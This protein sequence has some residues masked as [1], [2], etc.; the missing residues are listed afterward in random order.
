MKCFVTIVN[1]MLTILENHF[2]WDVWQGTEDDS[3]HGLEVKIKSNLKAQGS[4]TISIIYEFFFSYQSFVSQTLKIWNAEE[5][6]GSSLFLSTS[7]THSRTLTL[8]YFETLHLKT[9][10]RN[11]TKNTFLFQSV[12]LWVI[13]DDSIRILHYPW[14]IFA[15]S[16]L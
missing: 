5:G 10:T 4:Y 3:K 9:C 16:N 6:S 1:G 13:I 15:A 8:I 2:I 7:S 12:M 11:K 14:D